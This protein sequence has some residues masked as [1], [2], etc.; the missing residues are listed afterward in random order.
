MN[1]IKFSHE[2]AKLQ[3][4][5]EH[6]ESLL[7]MAKRI[8]LL[9]VIVVN[10]EDLNHHF[11]NYD[12]DFGVYKLPDKGKYML[13]LFQKNNGLMPTLRRWTPEKE[14]YYKSKIGEE[15]DVQIKKEVL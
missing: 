7:T 10:L 6:D 15:F 3:D 2:Y 1:S 13:L 8:V 11:L 14:I 4:T 9:E 5:Q 12:T